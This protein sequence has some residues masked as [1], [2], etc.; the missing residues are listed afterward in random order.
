MVYLVVPPVFIMV[1]LNSWMVYSMEHPIKMDD[2]WGL[3]FVLGN[4]Y[5]GKCILYGDNFFGVL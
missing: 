3:P 4:R 2:D 1:Y 5:M